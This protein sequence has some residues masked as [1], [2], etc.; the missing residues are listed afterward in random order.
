[1]IPQMYLVAPSLEMYSGVEIERSSM[2]WILYKVLG[3]SALGAMREIGV[4][5][6]H[7]LMMRSAVIVPVVMASCFVVAEEVNQAMIGW[8]LAA[9]FLAFVARRVKCGEGGTFPRTVVHFGFPA[10]VE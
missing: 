2:A 6:S 7:F 1:M 8:V 9:A 10:R 5:M 4:T 3:R